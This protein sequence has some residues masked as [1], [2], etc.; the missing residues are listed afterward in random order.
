MKL[1][2]N[3][4]SSGR[5][6]SEVPH[7]QFV[8]AHHSPKCYSQHVEVTAAR[9]RSHAARQQRLKPPAAWHGTSGE[10]YEHLF[11]RRRFWCGF[12]ASAFV[13]VDMPT[14][15]GCVMMQA[16]WAEYPLWPCFLLFARNLK[17][18]PKSHAR[19]G[20]V[21]FSR[22]NSRIR[23]SSFAGRRPAAGRARHSGCP[24]CTR[25]CRCPG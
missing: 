4:R 22:P 11:S 16:G 20:I 25:V 19:A 17:T 6:G 3:P 8:V 14:A 5:V 7:S 15:R 24:A 23:P 18:G 21:D 12:H 1:T 9:I 2:P 13:N 10:N